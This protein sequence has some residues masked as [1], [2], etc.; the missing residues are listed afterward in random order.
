MQNIELLNTITWH[1]ECMK[2]AS[3]TID[4]FRPPADPFQMR[5]H[6]SIYI[7][8]FMSALDMLKEVFG[9]SFTDALDKAFESPDT[10]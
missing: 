3:D 2:W 1:L 4:N 9:P 8:N 5:M 10:S 6:Y 7:T